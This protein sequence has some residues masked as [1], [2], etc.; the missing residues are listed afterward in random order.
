MFFW[1]FVYFYVEQIK[2]HSIVLH[3]RSQGRASQSSLCSSCFLPN[4]CFSICGLRVMVGVKAI[5]EGSVKGFIFQE[6][7]T[8]FWLQQYLRKYWNLFWRC[9]GAGPSLCSSPPSVCI[10]LSTWISFSPDLWIS[11][12]LCWTAE[13]CAETCSGEVVCSLQHWDAWWDSDYYWGFH[14]ILTIFSTIKREI[15]GNSLKILGWTPRGRLK[16]TAVSTSVVPFSVPT[17]NDF[18]FF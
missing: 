7:S 1:L 4:Q 5:S 8:S 18:F 13:L 2:H 6:I 15:K 17:F 16:S 3:T 9:Q 14:Y 12:W 11:F 10:L